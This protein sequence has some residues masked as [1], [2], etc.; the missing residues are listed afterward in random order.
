MQAQDDNEALTAEQSYDTFGRKTNFIAE[1]ESVLVKNRQRFT[2]LSLLT[3]LGVSALALFFLVGNSSNASYSS[4]DLSTS[5]KEVKGT[6]DGVGIAR[7]SFLKMNLYK[8]TAVVTTGTSSAAALIASNYLAPLIETED[9][10]CS[11]TIKEVFDLKHPAG[12]STHFAEFHFLDS[13]RFTQTG[14]PFGDWA[15]YVGSLGTVPFNVYLHNKLQMYVPDVAPLY[16]KLIANGVAASAFY[17]L[18]KSPGSD[19]YDVAHVGIFIT[20][21]VTVYEVVGPSSSLT[22]EEL[23]AF[24]PWSENECGNANNIPKTLAKYQEIYD[25]MTLTWQE[26]AWT[27][28]NGL[29]VP[30]AIAIVTSVS[31]LDRIANHVQAGALITNGNVTTEVISDSCSMLT[32]DFDRYKADGVDGFNAIVRYIENNQAYQGKVLSLEN[33]ENEV[34]ASHAFSLGRVDDAGYSS[35]NHYLDHHIG[36]ISKPQAS[37]GTQ[38][39]S[40]SRAYIEAVLE[41]YDLAFAP[42]SKYSTHYFTGTNGIRS[43]EFNI[44]ACNYPDKYTFD[45][46]GCLASNNNMEYQAIYNSSCLVT[47]FS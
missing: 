27:N 43:W 41:E 13:S 2:T 17:H 31:S 37:L 34:E 10:G 4:T 21:A 44:D 32:M 20:E 1:D 9:M 36:I 30:M 11:T 35:W 16:R 14:M 24:T 26:K 45:L 33:W 42:R 46:C 39:C 12:N 5:K 28:G 23:V 15:D 38:Y 22:I 40:E 6:Q 47:V 25:G 18:S 19:T 3:A 7:P 29:H 8:H